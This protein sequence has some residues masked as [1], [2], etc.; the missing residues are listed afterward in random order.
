MRD[1]VTQE[2]FGAWSCGWV[3]F[4]GWATWEES[5]GG[6]GGGEKRRHRDEADPA[7]TDT[8]AN[9]SRLLLLDLPLPLLCFCAVCTL[10]AL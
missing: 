9:T 8:V 6:E 10:T 4:G 1:A 7:K 5:K 3:G 2:Y